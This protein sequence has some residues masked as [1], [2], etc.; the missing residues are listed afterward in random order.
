MKQLYVHIYQNYL[1]MVNI[2]G[3]F[4]ILS[5]NNEFSYISPIVFGT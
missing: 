4:Y 5:T 1:K 3:S 2:P